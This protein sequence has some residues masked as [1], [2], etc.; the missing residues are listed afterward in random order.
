MIALRGHFDGK[1]IVPDEPV[2]L[3]Q[4]RPLI[5]HV[6]VEQPEQTKRNVSASELAGDLIGSVEGPEDLSTNKKHMRGYGK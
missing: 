6:Q 5:V 4:G 3:P 2:D 1:S